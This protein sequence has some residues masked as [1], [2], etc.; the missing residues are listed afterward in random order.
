MY[1][2][3]SG[4]QHGK[5]HPEPGTSPT[6]PGREALLHV[7][8]AS[9]A[10]KIVAISRSASGRRRNNRDAAGNGAADTGSASSSRR[11]SMDSEPCADLPAGPGYA[12]ARLHGARLSGHAGELPPLPPPSLGPDAFGYA[13][14]PLP[15]GARGQLPKPFDPSGD[16]IQ[17]LRPPSSD[18][19]SAMLLASQSAFLQPC[20]PLAPLQDPV[21]WMDQGLSAPLEHQMLST[22]PETGMDVG[23]KANGAGKGIA[24][25]SLLDLLPNS[26]DSTPTVDGTD[27]NRSSLDW[28]PSP[29]S[30]LAP[31]HAAELS[32]GAPDASPQ[33]ALLPP[34]SDASVAAL[35][36]QLASLMA[37]PH[38]Q[39]RLGTAQGLLTQ[40][41]RQGSPPTALMRTATALLEI[42]L[43][44]PAFMFALSV[45]DF[46]PLWQLSGIFSAREKQRRCLQWNA[47]VD[48]Y[49]QGEK[50]VA[51]WGLSFLIE[52]NL[53]CEAYLME[54]QRQ[55]CILNPPIEFH[56]SPLIQPQLGAMPVR[57]TS[58]RWRLN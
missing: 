2:L 22:M 24:T 51:G 43:V 21:G 30:L 10:P 8:A 33:A 58:L 46:M 44:D 26:Y 32:M 37:N 54:S 1:G 49:I 53:G 6:A 42:G 27:S 31:G 57:A 9:V 56:L 34:G 13:V 40:A 25:G 20:A 4:E 52:W 47:A 5:G 35:V 17:F 29:R 39:S 19:S 50:F 23:G 36:E 41:D 11:S 12:S 55:H 28:E 48:A 14:G 45:C 16:G 15:S 38:V 18:V 7:F 3:K